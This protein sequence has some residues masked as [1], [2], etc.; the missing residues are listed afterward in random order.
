[1]SSG[2]GFS[3][4]RKGREQGGREG[5]QRWRVESYRKGAGQAELDWPTPGSISTLWLKGKA[6]MIP[7]L[8]GHCP[9]SVP[10][11]GQVG[12]PTE[13]RRAG[14]SGDVGGWF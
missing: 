3:K 4:G 7:E 5:M 12:Q 13:G 14:I 10:T 8:P 11:V 2:R 6:G 1:M 9:I